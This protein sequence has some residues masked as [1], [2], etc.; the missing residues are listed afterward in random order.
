MLRHAQQHVRGGTVRFFFHILRVIPMHLPWLWRR[1]VKRHSWR[2]LPMRVLL[3]YLV[4]FDV[5]L[6]SDQSNQPWTI[7]I[8]NVTLF[9]YYIFFSRN[10]WTEALKPTIFIGL[11]S[12]LS[13]DAPDHPPPLESFLLLLRMLDELPDSGETLNMQMRRQPKSVYP[14]GS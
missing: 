12:D 1:R 7:N 10:T 8:Y 6:L 4:C 5:P 9:L 2:S 3:K 11:V 13:T 14:A